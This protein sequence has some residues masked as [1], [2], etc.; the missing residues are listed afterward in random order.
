MSWVESL[1]QVVETEIADN[2]PVIRKQLPFRM[3]LCHEDSFLD[4]LKGG[5]WLEI[6]ERPKG[7]Q[8]IVAYSLLK[9]KRVR[10]VRR[11]NDY[12]DYAF[13]SNPRKVFSW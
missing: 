1:R 7:I 11:E 12:R 10:F 13:D 8:K 4:H 6:P 5:N 3:A 2:P 9:L